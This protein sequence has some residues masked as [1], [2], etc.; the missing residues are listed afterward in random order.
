MFCLYWSL[1]FHLVIRYHVKCIY[2][3]ERWWEN[4]TFRYIVKNLTHPHSTFVN[5]GNSIIKIKL[6]TF[7]CIS[8]SVSLSSALLFSFVSFSHFSF[9]VPFFSCF[10]FLGLMFPPFV[11][12][13]IV[14]SSLFLSL[15]LSL[16]LSSK[17]TEDS[18]TKNMRRLFACLLLCVLV[19]VCA[20]SL[21]VC[22]YVYPYV[23]NI[24]SFVHV[25]VCF[26]ACLYTSGYV[27][28]WLRACNLCMSVRVR[29]CACVRPCACVC[30]SLRGRAVSIPTTE[31]RVVGAAQIMESYSEPISSGYICSISV[32]GCKCGLLIYEWADLHSW[33]RRGLCAAAAETRGGP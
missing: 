4:K 20:R 5:L 23:L 22:V 6:L 25:R 8:S 7:S 26:C 3:K 9:L 30:V 1:L 28:A 12:T 27:S 29:A 15:S 33:Y 19:F 11:L 14:F 10:F 31:G 32:G 13:F 18:W 24:Y 17:N 16:F 21:I 2:R